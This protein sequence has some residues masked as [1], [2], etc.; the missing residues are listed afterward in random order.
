MDSITRSAWSVKSNGP[1]PSMRC[2]RWG[3]TSFGADAAGLVRDVCRNVPP[4]RSIVRT[5]FGVERH[6]PS[7]TR[8]GIVGVELEQRR[9][10]APEADHLVALV[11][12]TVDDGLDAGVEPRHVAAPGQDPDP[13]RSSPS[14]SARR[15]DA[16]RRG[17]RPGPGTGPGKDSRL[18]GSPA[19][20]V[21]RRRRRPGQR[22]L[23]RN[24]F[25]RSCCGASKS[26]PA[27][28]PR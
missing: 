21:P 28:P 2:A 25:V 27:C 13:H 9:P 6:E 12:D 8:T 24:C 4:V 17:G 26:A 14:S 7:V 22:I 23:E 3:G 11:H 5:T 16:S 15:P 20:R 10:A 1:S 19:S 18:F